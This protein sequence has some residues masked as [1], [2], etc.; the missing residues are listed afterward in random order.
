MHTGGTRGHH[1]DARVDAFLPAL[2][3]ARHRSL[4]PPLPLT[5][6]YAAQPGTAPRSRRPAVTPRHPHI[7][8]V[9]L[10]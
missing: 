10:L 1:Y 8:T 9:G 7:H 3:E 4:P 6:T 5:D 2:L